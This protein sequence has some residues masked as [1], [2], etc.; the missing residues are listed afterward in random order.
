MDP[1]GVRRAGLSTIL[2]V[3]GVLALACESGEAKAGEEL[4]R[5]RLEPGMEL[6]YKGSSLFR[7]EGGAHL[8]DTETT[9]WVLRRNEDGS[10]RILVRQGSRFTAARDSESASEESLRKKAEEGEMRFVVGYFDLFP[11]GR[12]GKDAE[13][14]FRIRPD[15]V[16]P[17]LPDDQAQASA[18]WSV[19]ETPT[20]DGTRYAALKP[21]EGGPS[22]KAERLG[23]TNKIYGST[24]ESTFHFDSKRGLI[25]GVELRYTQT[26][27]FNG[28]G[29]GKTELASVETRDDAWT[30]AFAQG[31]E[32]YFAANKAYEKATEESARAGDKAGDVL[33]KAKEILASARKEI[34][35]PYFQKQIDSQISSHDGMIS[36]YVKS[37]N[38]RAEVVG[39]PAPDWELKDFDGKSHAIED[40]RGKVVVLDFWY[41]GCG[42]CIK[43][44]PQL[45]ELAEQ[46]QGR[47]VVLLGMNTDRKVEDAKFVQ[48]QMNL[49]YETLLNAT[50]VPKK[51]G[52]QGF[53]TLV[54]ID[55][56][57]IVR[58]FH[59]GF[60]PTLRTE[61]TKVIEELLPSK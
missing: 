21:E 29:E 4:P 31:A 12:L 25:K 48:E 1:K 13:L 19:E 33:A 32:R 7:F 45:N 42:W 10:V 30:K 54:V 47:P 35:D 43:A 52:V 39:K 58:D 38:Q 60:S 11:D 20:E 56:E 14:A 22:F 40:Y 59:V 61:L 44:M 49:K 17:R 55:P 6:T 5:Y 16:F 53:P 50:E 37:A 3:V 24:Q 27:G 18:G 36:Y 9:A 51:Y 15:S 8:D 46:F 26:Y 23:T 2:V 28:K 34:E 57:G 41:R